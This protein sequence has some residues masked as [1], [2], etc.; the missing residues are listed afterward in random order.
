MQTV[1]TDELRTSELRDLLSELVT[2]TSRFTRLAASVSP[3]DHP[4]TWSRALSLLDEYGAIR[5]SE[6]ARL[7]RCSQPSATALLRTLGDNGLVTRTSD[8]TDS[9]A[10]VVAISESGRTWLA[11]SRRAIGD[12]LLQH[13]H[14]PDPAQ[15]RRIVEGLDDLRSVLKNTA[16]E[17]Q[18]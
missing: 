14:R 2:S 15:L 9:R 4:R 5:V 6:F 11:E 10:V 7:D 18:S 3:T 16:R 12:G 17:E 1:A 13:L 8:P